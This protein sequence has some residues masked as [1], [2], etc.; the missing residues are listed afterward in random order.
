MSQLIS[1]LKIQITTLE[2]Q[3]RQSLDK[4][5]EESDLKLQTLRTDYDLQIS[6][7]REKHSTTE[8]SLQK[9]VESNK[10]LTRQISRLKNIN[11]DQRNEMIRMVEAHDRLQRAA[12]EMNTLRFRSIVSDVDGLSQGLSQVPIE[13]VEES[14]M[15]NSR[16]RSRGGE[17]PLRMRSC[18]SGDR[19]PLGLEN[20][21]K[22]RSVEP[23]ERQ[24]ITMGIATETP[25]RIECAGGQ[26]SPKMDLANENLD[27]PLRE[28]PLRLRSSKSMQRQVV[29]DTPRLPLSTLPNRLNVP[30]PSSSITQDEEDDEY[31]PLKKGA[32]HGTQFTDLIVDGDGFSQFGI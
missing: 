6:D 20:A 23:K 11:E 28:T 2:T 12:A 10:R 7:L 27:T 14:P 30:I 15:G 13:D 4:A 32:T 16:K 26:M 9:L 24:D 29:K 21:L 25:R 5:A 3:R 1:T 17:T 19:T 22:V 18:L 31:V 8:S